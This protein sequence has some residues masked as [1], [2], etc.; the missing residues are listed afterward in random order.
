MAWVRGQERLVYNRIYLAIRNGML[1]DLGWDGAALAGRMPWDAQQPLTIRDLPFDPKLEPVQPNLIALTEGLL[2]DDRDLELGAGLQETKHTIFVDV[3]AESIS[4]AK[5]LASDVRSILV[6]RAPNSSRYLD[7]PDYATAG[8]PI[9]AG[10]LIHFEDIEV[11]FPDG[12]GQAHWAVVKA[13]AVHEWT[14]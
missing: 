8:E 14:P 6:G 7:L 1:V 4:I 12:L 2:P 13:T 5:A 10:H 3:Y 11:A 9:L